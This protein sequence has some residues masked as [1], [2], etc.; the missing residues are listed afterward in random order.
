MN[1]NYCFDAL[2]VTI[3]AMFIKFK[4]NNIRVELHNQSESL[5]KRIREAEKQKIPY[6]LVVGEKEET[7]NF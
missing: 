5:G 1:S 7:D 2:I 3:L 6:M 4:E